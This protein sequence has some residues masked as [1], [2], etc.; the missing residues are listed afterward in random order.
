MNLEERLVALL[1][2]CPSM[3][4]V[5]QIHAQVIT[6]GLSKQ[7][8]FLTSRFIAFCSSSPLGDVRYARAVFDRVV[9]PSVFMWNSMIRGCSIT[10]NLAANDGFSLYKRMH[11]ENEAKPN[12]FT[13]NFV[14]KSCAAAVAVEE[15]KEVHAH[16]AKSGCF[17]SPHIRTT[18]VSM[19]VKCGEVSDAQQ[20]FDEMTERSLVAWSALVSG[21]ASA[22]MTTKALDLFRDMQLAGVTPDEVTLVGVISACA[23]AGALKMGRWVHAYVEKRTVQLDVVLGTALV[24]MYSKCGCIETARQLFVEMPRR[25]TMLWTCMIMGLAAHGLAC[26]ALEV[27]SQ[28]K[29]E[30][31]RQDAVTFIAVLSA[32]AHGGLVA[33]GKSCFDL[34]IKNGISPQVEHYACMVDLLCRAGQVDEAYEFVRDMPL[35]PNAV[36]W[37][38]LLVACR[39]SGNVTMG[40]AIGKCLLEAEPFSGE[41]YVLFSN[42]YAACSRWEEVGIVRKMMKQRRVKANPGCSSVEIDGVVLEFL[43]WDES[44]PRAKE[45]YSVLHHLMLAVRN[46]GYDEFRTSAVLRDIGDEGDFLSERTAKRCF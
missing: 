3:R 21:Y 2:A 34:M 20:A 24:D 26:D 9:R 10:G 32:C 13:F 28:M 23:Q 18:M 30:N 39:N 31:V 27:F 8:N 22:G 43:K 35:K 4:V 42:L 25:D 45:L 36:M 40:E 14:L 29:L 46:G 44:Y 41:N 16:V 7:P 12:S 38:T 5:L 37:R 17:W 11:S 15:G 1:G 19:Y 6:N 33:E